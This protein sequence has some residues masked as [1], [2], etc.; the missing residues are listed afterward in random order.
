[1]L[2]LAGWWWIGVSIIHALGGIIIYFAQWQEIAQ[3]GWFN[4]VAPDPLAPIFPREDAFWFMFLTPFL[5]ILG[6]LC[7]W[8]NHQELVFPISISIILI[9]TMIIG[10]FLMPVSGIWLALPSI[11]LM[12]YSSKIAQSQDK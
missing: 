7:L 11:I 4:A 1:M 9:C 5:F 3:A 2:W 6:K 10:I 8:L 12:L